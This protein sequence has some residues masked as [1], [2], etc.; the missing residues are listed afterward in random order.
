MPEDISEKDVKRYENLRQE[1]QKI[2]QKRL[3]KN[4][5]EEM[6]EKICK[7]RISKDIS[8]KDVRKNIR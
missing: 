8:E 7:K 4:M 2:C 5:S 6:L 1:C 3:L